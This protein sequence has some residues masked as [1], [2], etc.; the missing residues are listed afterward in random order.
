MWAVRREH[1]P[2]VDFLLRHLTAE[3]VTSTRNAQGATAVDFVSTPAI[4]DLFAG[5]CA[6]NGLESLTHSR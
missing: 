5:K 4:R 3:Q 6:W 1:A 2:I